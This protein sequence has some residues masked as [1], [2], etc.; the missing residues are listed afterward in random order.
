MYTCSLLFTCIYVLR[1]PSFQPTDTIHFGARSVR[2]E[3]SFEMMW[4]SI[5]LTLP[6][7]FKQKNTPVIYLILIV[8]WQ[9]SGTPLVGVII[10]VVL[11]VD[12][13]VI[14]QCHVLKSQCFECCCFFDVLSFCPLQQCIVA[15][16][17]LISLMEIPRMMCSLNNTLSFNLSFKNDNKSTIHNFTK[18]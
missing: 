2:F 12:L 17:N 11:A 14:G 5:F 18:K 8:L 9:S 10:D 1:F 7:K 3:N 15:Q 6:Q 4:T 13:Q 16:N